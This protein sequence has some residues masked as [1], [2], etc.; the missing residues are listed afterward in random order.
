ARGSARARC[1]RSNRCAQGWRNWHS[2][3]PWHTEQAFSTFCDRRLRRNRVIAVRARRGRFTAL[4]RTLPVADR[5]ASPCPEAAISLR[6]SALPCVVY[7]S[8]PP[9][10]AFT[11]IDKHEAHGIL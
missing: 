9:T 1:C 4:L 10:G 5:A 11:R 2:A 3:S 7:C 8:V 6:S